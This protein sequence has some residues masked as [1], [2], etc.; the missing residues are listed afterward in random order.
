MSQMTIRERILRN[1]NVDVAAL[2]EQKR[3]PKEI[4]EF[5]LAT[6]V[7]PQPS[8]LHAKTYLTPNSTAKINFF[9]LHATRGNLYSFEPIASCLSFMFQIYALYIPVSALKCG[10][11][12]S[13][14]E[15]FLSEITAVQP[16]GPYNIMGFSFGAWIAHALV[17]I[18]NTKG[19]EA[20]LFMLDPIPFQT[21]DEDVLKNP[22]RLVQTV[23]KYGNEFI[24]NALHYSESDVLLNFIQNFCEQ[25]SLLLNY[26]HSYQPVSSLTT[27]ILARDGIALLEDQKYSSPTFWNSLCS[28]DKLMIKLVPGNHAAC[29]GPTYC[30][31]ITDIVLQVFNVQI[32]NATVLISSVQN[33]QGNWKLQSCYGTDDAKQNLNMTAIDHSHLKIINTTY[34]CIIPKVIEFLAELNMSECREIAGFLNSAGTVETTQGSSEMQFHVE[35]SF[36]YSENLPYQIKATVKV[37][38][39]ILLLC[40]DNIV[41]SFSKI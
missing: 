21:I 37:S 5:V 24:Q 3:S 36:L 7:G 18:L 16:V 9:I 23:I 41:F 39:G 11:M 27:V 31:Y 33:I 40:I 30:H 38:R 17:S 19:E 12:E 29:I 26:K 22:H 14:A 25:Y 20:V 4:A 8:V 15:Y 2:L 34:I 6:Y 28:S 32:E 1:F 35:C 13:Y 10:S